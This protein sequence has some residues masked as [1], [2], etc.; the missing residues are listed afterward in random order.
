MQKLRVLHVITGTAV[1]GAEMMLA[2]YLKALGSD[3][4][5]HAVVSMMPPGPVA[6]MIE[7]LDVPV[8]TLAMSGAKGLPA[9]VLRLRRQMGNNPPDVIHGWMYHG[10]LVA[11]LAV[12]MGGY[13]Q[14]GLV[15]AIHHS[16]SDLRREKPMTRS[17]LRL[18]RKLQRRADVIT[19]C[20]HVSRDQHRRFG[21]NGGQDWLIP[22]A[23]DTQEFAPDAAARK[24]LM[25]QLGL[26]GD[27][28]F[29]GN[30]GRAHPMKDH[31]AFARAIGLMADQGLNVHGIVIGEGQPDG[32]AVHMARQMGIADRLTALPARADIAALIP[33]LDLYMLS[34]AWGEA[35][36]LAV[37]EAMAAGVPAIVTDIGD[38]GWLVGHADQICPPRRPEL[39]A[40]AGARILA[41]SPV[42]RTELAA[43][44]RERIMHEMALPA[45]VASHQAAYRAA[46]HRRSGNLPADDE[47]NAA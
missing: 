16:L 2:R 20:S 47:R 19:Y 23:I 15:W 24:R 26:P 25:Q 31:A 37:A 22:N 35:L 27:R 45:Y 40:S 17:V 18:L 6:R 14:T 8:T 33:G 5:N 4:R 42:A 9:A 41:M 39:L 30:V 10:C 34:S 38:C 46:A 32:P 36:P 1:G 44:G 29:V 13:R 28:L 7:S 3:R 11:A 12:S 43:R 21:L